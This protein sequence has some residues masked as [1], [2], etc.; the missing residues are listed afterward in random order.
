MARRAPPGSPK[1]AC[2]RD[3]AW[4]AASARPAV[5]RGPALGGVPGAH[6]LWLCLGVVTEADAFGEEA[7]VALR[8]ELPG[9]ETVICMD[10]PGRRTDLYAG[11]PVEALAEALAE[12]RDQ[13][14]AQPDLYVCGPPE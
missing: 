6:P 11:S 10:E 5:V 13:G 8:D 9:L 3:G 2:G 1:P 14:G 7:L 12:L 4:P